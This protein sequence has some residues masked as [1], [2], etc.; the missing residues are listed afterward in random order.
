MNPLMLV[1]LT[2]A[3][4]V[5]VIA[6][7]GIF[8]ALTVC[9]CLGLKIS[10]TYSDFIVGHIAWNAAT[11]FQDIVIGPAVIAVSFVG[12]V[13]FSTLLNKLRKRYGGDHSEQLANQFIWWS[14]PGVAGIVGLFLKPGL[15]AGVLVFS[16]VFIVVLS[17]IS[18]VNYLK[19]TKINME[20]VGVFMI[21]VVLISL[22]PLEVYLV[23]GRV[24][25]I[26]L[27]GNE[28]YPYVKNAAI[29]IFVSGVGLIFYCGIFN[30]KI[31]ESVVR[32]LIFIGQ[33]GLP[34][35]FLLMY[36]AEFVFS[37]G[38]VATYSTTVFL[39]MLV[40]VF[41]LAG[42]FD[43]VRRYLKNK[44]GGELRPLFSP[45]AI[46][47]VIV[48]LK[49]GSTLPP[50]ISPDDYHF[51]ERLLGWW[52]YVQGAI[53]YLDYI[54]PHG[55]IHDD[56]AM[57]LSS[58]FYDGAA[59]SHGQAYRLGF[60]IFSFVAFSSILTFSKSLEFSF[61]VTLFLPGPLSWAFF[62][63]FLCLFFNEK[64]RRNPSKWLIAWMVSA[65]IIVL[66]SPGQGLLLVVS[67]G[68]MAV[69]FAWIQWRDG[70]KRS[71][72]SVGVTVGALLVVAVSTPLG[73]MLFAAIR[74]VLE[75]GPIN[76]L[77]YGISWEDGLEANKDKGLLFMLTQMSW[78][79]IAILC[80]TIIYFKRTELKKIDGIVY[81]AV[82]IFLFILLIIPYSMGRIGANSMS[83]A[84]DISFAGWV[85]L[86]PLAV[87]PM[88]KL[89]NKAPWFLL[90]AC[91]FALFPGFF[92]NKI[93][94]SGL[95]STV[96]SAVKTAPLRN[97]QSVG[98]GN[99]G[100]AHVN[101]EHWNRLIRLNA[102]FNAKLSP[103]E[104]YLDLT[105]RNAQYFYLNRKPAVEVTAPYNMV[106]PSQQKRVVERL[107]ENPPPLALLQA[108][109]IVHDG[110]GLALR[111]PIL[112]RFVVDNYNPFFEDGFI[113]GY[114]RTHDDKS[115]INA[116]IKN[117][118]D[119]NW[120]RGLQRRGIAVILDDSSLN[121]FVEVGD[122]IRIGGELRRIKEVWKSGLGAVWF[123]GAPVVLTD[124][125]DGNFVQFVVDPQ[126][127]NEYKAS[128]FQRAFAISDLRKLPVSWGRSERSLQN[129]MVLVGGLD[130]IPKRYNHVVADNNGYKVTGNDP[131]VRMDVSGMSISG[132]DAGLL[133]FDFT[134]HGQ[135]K[136]PRIQIF[137]WGDNHYHPFEA[138][139][140]KFTAETGTLIVPLD[141]SPSWLT[142]HS[143]RGIRIDLHDASACS[144]FSIENAGLYQRKF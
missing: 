120:E 17:V 129:K 30:D 73:G 47:A 19:K 60:V 71:W 106:S 14:I 81:P 55:I 101:D 142:L 12:L 113:L 72:I 111:S 52:S 107:S 51:G 134:C 15:N 59:V 97:G 141:S 1:R 110:G 135:R 115:T 138:S 49:H 35:L 62:A 83:R 108:R 119:M 16:A 69:R 64:L 82:T 11:K 109:N 9:A 33:L 26:L 102:L 5:A 88:I 133:K 28:L 50:S 132:R 124:V 42:F 123:E 31:Q 127:A 75:N 66:A 34:F 2:L 29:V 116:A 92:I 23:V 8:S 38:D 65:P 99:I 105:S 143:V 22:V 77:A 95:F 13:L 78:M 36:P 21:S 61:L 76:Q 80:A 137:W 125:A 46:F 25:D 87:W 39:R 131:F 44:K 70:D 45:V 27:V 41:V 130:G 7:A 10:P 112:Y 54:P 91:V 93:S 56:V 118:T 94:Y 67:S 57:F 68:V 43:V 58:V 122:Y 40:F 24:A 144:A 136:E 98:L 126:R 48:L 139:S 96:S 20:V 32:R 89:K 114:R 86:L 121:S 6:A 90:I 128:L 140:L 117:F 4:K 53:P 3:E 100:N 63:I 84:G 85:V 79:V 104:T 103:D 37:N 18:I 74:Y